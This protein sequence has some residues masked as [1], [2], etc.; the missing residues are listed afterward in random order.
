MVADNFALQ[1]V[2][3][4]VMTRMATKRL[5]KVRG[6]FSPPRQVLPSFGT[7]SDL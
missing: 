3:D 1:Q 6:K 2:S 4:V 5:R 7:S